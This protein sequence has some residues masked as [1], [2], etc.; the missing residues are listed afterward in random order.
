M[1]TCQKPIEQ[2][3]QNYTSYLFYYVLHFLLSYIKVARVSEVSVSQ[4]KQFQ[5]N[6][7]DICVANIDGK[8]FAINN[9]C[10]HE[11]G[12]LAD[13]KLEGNEVECPWHQSK[14]DMTTGEVKSPP[15]TEPQA[16]YEVKIE[17]DDI[18]V[19]L[20]YDKSEKQN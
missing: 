10:S 7:Q 13:G 20:D 19:K 4:M 12:P 11:G 3:S 18:M 6:G 16:V 17:G 15:A 9:I 2:W 5:L 8:F 14:F 1:I